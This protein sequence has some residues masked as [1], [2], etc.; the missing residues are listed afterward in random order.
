MNN[1]QGQVNSLEKET[2]LL[3]ARVDQLESAVGIPRV[4][5]SCQSLAASGVN[6]NGLYL[7]QPNESVDAFEV[8]TQK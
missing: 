8:F 5:R 2:Q 7:I 4:P 1:L 6:V 3:E